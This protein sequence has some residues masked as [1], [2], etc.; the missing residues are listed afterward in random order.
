MMHVD[1]ERISLKIKGVDETTKEVKLMYQVQI[2]RD[3]DKSNMELIAQFI[4]K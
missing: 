1:E 4:Q 2:N 3:T